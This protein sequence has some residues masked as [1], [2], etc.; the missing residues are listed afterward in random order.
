MHRPCNE[1]IEFLRGG[2]GVGEG[3]GKEEGIGG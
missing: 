1:W 3:G 2:R